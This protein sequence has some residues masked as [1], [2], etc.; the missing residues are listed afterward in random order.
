MALC[1]LDNLKLFPFSNSRGKTTALLV[2]DAVCQVSL[3]KNTDF[4][5]EMGVNG[6]LFAWH[7]HMYFYKQK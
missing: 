3:L 2:F 7:N 5:L 1:D 4:K 6:V